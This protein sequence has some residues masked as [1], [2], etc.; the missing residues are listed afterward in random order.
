MTGWKDIKY[1]PKDGTK[2]LLLDSKRGYLEVSEWDLRQGRWEY[3]PEPT[4]FMEIPPL[5]P[6]ILEV[7]KIYKNGWGTEILIVGKARTNTKYEFIGQ[8][9]KE[10]S[11]EVWLRCFTKYGYIDSDTP[12]HIENLIIEEEE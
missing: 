12:K 4:H 2:I 7:G 5:P 6:K 10:K 3:I 11:P 9:L 8:V 1:A